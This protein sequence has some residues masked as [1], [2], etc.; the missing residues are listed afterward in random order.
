MWQCKSCGL[1]NHLSSIKCIACFNVNPYVAPTVEIGD[2]WLLHH[3]DQNR[4]DHQFKIIEFNQKVYLLI[5]NH[6]NEISMIE[7][8][9]LKSKLKSEF[10]FDYNYDDTVDSANYNLNKRTGTLYIII[11]RSMVSWNNPDNKPD[12]LSLIIYNM[13]EMSIKKK[14]TLN[15]TDPRLDLHK[16]SNLYEIISNNNKTLLTN[17][18]HTMSL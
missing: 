7:Y 4:G 13:N 12:T 14:Y 5:I 6:K 11:Q 10:S 1:F 8:G 9:Q 16:R 3:I 17:K 2:K 18:N 15:C